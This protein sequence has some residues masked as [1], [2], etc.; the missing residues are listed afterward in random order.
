MEEFLQNICLLK[1]LEMANYNQ[2]YRN[3]R[4]KFFRRY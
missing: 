2:K 1:N 4:S 3:N